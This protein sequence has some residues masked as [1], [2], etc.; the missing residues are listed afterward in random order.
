MQKELEKEAEEDEATYDKIVCWCNTNDKEK[1]KSI[2]QAETKIADLTKSI[3]EGT[4]TSAKL[5]TE[6]ANLKKEVAANQNA[7]DKAGAMR[8][9]DLAE[10][11]AEEKDL[12][13]SIG[14]LKSAITVLSKH[15]GGAALLQIT[16]SQLLQ[17]ATIMQH[18]MIKNAAALEGVLTRTQKKKIEAFA[19]DRSNY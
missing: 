14:A 11:T 17:V 15:H 9:K 2:K 3:E 8:T 10:F 12:L 13:Q 16:S 5:N 19:Q 1:T 4:A 18:E 6:I 7:L